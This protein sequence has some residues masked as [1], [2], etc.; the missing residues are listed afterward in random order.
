MERIFTSIALNPQGD[1]LA[2]G[3]Q[4]GEI[5]LWDLISGE[6]LRTMSDTPG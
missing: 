3:N 4:D 2:M 5:I 1:V 6:K